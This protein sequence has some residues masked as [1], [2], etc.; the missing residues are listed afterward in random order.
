MSTID[1]DIIKYRTHKSTNGINH[2]YF[3]CLHRGIW[4]KP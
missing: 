1:M 3:T 2:H 4:A